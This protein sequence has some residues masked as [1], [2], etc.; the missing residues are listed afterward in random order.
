ME[1]DNDVVHNMEFKKA[2]D[3]YKQFVFID[4][5]QENQD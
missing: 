3:F 1:F 2:L 5:S 4:M